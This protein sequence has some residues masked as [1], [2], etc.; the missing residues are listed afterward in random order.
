MTAFL[1]MIHVLR[2]PYK[3]R[4]DLTEWSKFETGKFWD[5]FLAGYL[6]AKY[7]LSACPVLLLYHMDFVSSWGVSPAN[8]KKLSKIILHC[9]RPGE[10]VFFKEIVSGREV[11]AKYL[12]NSR[13]PFQIDSWICFFPDLTL[14]HQFGQ[15]Y[16]PKD[17]AFFY[18]NM[19][20]TIALFGTE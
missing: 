14:H 11:Y 12:E 2:V 19:L 20:H 7:I 9:G 15:V 10:D 18:S 8:H 6:F 1:P 3:N 5:P 4:R 16:W 13:C 17:I